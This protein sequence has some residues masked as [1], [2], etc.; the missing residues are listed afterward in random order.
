MFIYYASPLFARVV[1]IGSSEMLYFNIVVVRFSLSWYGDL[2]Q[3]EF[4]NLGLEGEAVC[5]I[6]VSGA[7]KVG[8]QSVR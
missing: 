8:P 5:Q 6:A 7:W 3:V 4:K 1:S 2:F